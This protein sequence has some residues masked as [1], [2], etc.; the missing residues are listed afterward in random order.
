MGPGREYAT[1]LLPITWKGRGISSNKSGDFDLVRP[2][3]RL[4]EIG[5][6]WLAWES[7]ILRLFFDVQVTLFDVCDHRQFAPFKKYFQYFASCVDEQ[8]AMNV[9]ERTRVHSLLN[10][11]AET[12]NWSE[13]YRLLGHDYIIDADRLLAPLPS[14]TYA[15]VFSAAVLEHLRRALLRDEVADF[16]RVLR[17]GGHSM[18]QIDLGD[19]LAYH[20]DA[21]SCVKNYLR[22]SERTWGALFENGVQYFNR[23]QPAE[24]LRAFA[25]AGLVLK[26]ESRISIDLS[27]IKIAAQFAEMDTVDLACRTL[28]ILHQKPAGE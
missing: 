14:N 11:I 17:P 21:I 10:C 1:C 7:T 18:H 23:V 28:R 13:A 26:D 2:G 8:I 19:H 3:D 12:K 15:L 4:L 25:D 27:G 16:A 20:D 9:K 6:G 22:Y 24:W 5:S